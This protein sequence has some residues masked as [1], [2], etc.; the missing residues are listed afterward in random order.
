MPD[1]IGRRRRACAEEEAMQ[2]PGLRDVA[3]HFGGDVVA[4][5]LT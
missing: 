2:C 5:A 4:H 3:D 1:F